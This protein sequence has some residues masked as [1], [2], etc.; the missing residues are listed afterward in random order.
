M[1]IN[2]QIV[3]VWQLEVETP[4]FCQTPVLW[5]STTHARRRETEDAYKSGQHRNFFFRAVVLPFPRNWLITIYSSRPEQPVYHESNPVLLATVYPH[6]HFK[7]MIIDKQNTL[8]MGRNWQLGYSD[9]SGNE[10]DS[11]VWL[12][13]QYTFKILLKL[14]LLLLHINTIVTFLWLTSLSGNFDSH[15]RWHIDFNHAA[16][17]RLLFFKF[18]L[19]NR[20]RSSSKM[21]WTDVHSHRIWRADMVIMRTSGWDSIVDK[22]H[23]WVGIELRQDDWWSNRIG[24]W[25]KCCYNGDNVDRN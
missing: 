14:L 8:L 16:D 15:L 2:W 25:D 20:A 23:H 9:I 3:P 24:G 19:G 10:S 22:D 1:I 13:H 5:W 12:P 4:A 18:C 7:S 17:G 6:L 11:S 21:K